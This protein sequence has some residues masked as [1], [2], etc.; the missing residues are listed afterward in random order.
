MQASV[1]PEEGSRYVAVI[2]VVLF[3]RLKPLGRQV[4]KERGKRAARLAVRLPGMLLC[5]VAEHCDLR[6]YE[7]CCLLPPLSSVLVCQ[8]WEDLH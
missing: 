1:V 3:G 4:G 7:T 2:R 5:P 6:I 8:P